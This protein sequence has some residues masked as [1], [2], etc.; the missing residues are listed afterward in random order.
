L[1]DSVNSKR[2]DKMHYDTSLLLIVALIR[3]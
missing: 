1:S 2:N 3:W